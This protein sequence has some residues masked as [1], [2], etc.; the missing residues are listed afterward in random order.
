MAPAVAQAAGGSVTATDQ[1]G[2]LIERDR[3]LLSDE[4]E[5]LPVPFGDL[6]TSPVPPCSPGWSLFVEDRLGLL[7]QLDHFLP[8][9]LPG[10]LS[11]WFWSVLPPPS[12]LGVAAV[13]GDLPPSD[14][15]LV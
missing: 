5:Q 8:L 11:F 13:V 15:F 3:V 6:V 10:L 1:R 12:W 2:E 4:A 14:T 7:L 9:P